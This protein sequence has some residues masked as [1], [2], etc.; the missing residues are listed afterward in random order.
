VCARL[1]AMAAGVASP[2][3]EPRPRG[4]LRWGVALIVLGAAAGGGYALLPRSPSKDVQ[5]ITPSPSAE[6][7]VLGAEGATVEPVVRDVAP[8]TPAPVPVV[9]VPEPVVSPPLPVEPVVAVEPKAPKNTPNPRPPALHT[10]PECE[11]RRADVD[12]AVASRRWQDVLELSA[13]AECWSGG[14]SRKIARIHAFAGL[15]RYEDCVKSAGHGNVP[16]DVADMVEYCRSKLET[17]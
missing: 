15:K 11:K 6:A 17:P 13:R 8:S 10:T 16:P 5:P 14:S 2:R 1:G 3:L 9:E 4:W 12:D 7:A